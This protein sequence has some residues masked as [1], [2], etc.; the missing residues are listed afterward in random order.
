[1]KKYI[2]DYVYI[3]FIGIVAI[4]LAVLGFCI[5]QLFPFFIEIYVEEQNHDNHKV[6][7][8]VIDDYGITL[9]YEQN[10]AL[11]TAVDTKMTE[12]IS[13]SLEI[14]LKLILVLFLVSTFIA[15]VFGVRKLLESYIEPLHNMTKTAEELAVGN[16]QARA[17]AKGP[18]TIN[19]LRNSINIL[20]GNLQNITKIKWTKIGRLYHQT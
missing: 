20:A 5:G 15:T 9:D 13:E 14:R 8:N 2:G 4:V 17:F 7:H 19:A 16:Y 12:D 18:Q 1:M 3:Q 6:I 11:L 10:K